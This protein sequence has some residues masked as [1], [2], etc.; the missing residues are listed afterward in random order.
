M[1][2]KKNATKNTVTLKDKRQKKR[3]ILFV[4]LALLITAIALG[5]SYAYNETIEWY[6]PKDY[7]DI[8][9]EWSEYYE[10]DP[11]LIYAH[12]HTESSFD[13]NA[14]S[15]VGARGLMQITEDTF[16]WIKSK[17]ARDEDLTFDDLFDPDI[18]VRFGTYYISECLERY[19]DD[20]PTAAAAYHSGWGTVDTLLE[21]SA[22]SKNGETLDVFPYEQ[23]QHYVSKIAKSYQK[24]TELYSS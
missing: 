20:Q 23:M 3:L 24:Y 7:S 4:Y 2:S 15:N 5:I 9:E 17:I 16:D 18:N 19:S 1:Q 12:V 10:V 6:Y 22:Y 8:I 11:M 21:D 13:A 14:V